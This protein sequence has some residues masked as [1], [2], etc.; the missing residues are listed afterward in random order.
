MTVD[1][2][3][4]IKTYILPFGKQDVAY[5]NRGLAIEQAY[6]RCEKESLLQHLFVL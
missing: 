3:L 6:L 2:T 1:E 4:P 5:P